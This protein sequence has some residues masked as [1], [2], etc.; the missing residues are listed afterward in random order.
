MPTVGIFELMVLVMTEN[1]HCDEPPLPP[2]ENPVE[3]L[4]PW[5]ADVVP[6]V[7]AE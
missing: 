4:P 6:P 7:A 3:A 1:E 5:A 2:V